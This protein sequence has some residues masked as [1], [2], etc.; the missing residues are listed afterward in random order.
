VLRVD[1]YATAAVAGSLVM[2]IGGRLGLPRTSLALLGGAVCFTL[3]ML[4]VWQN[5][6]LPKASAF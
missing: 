2:V 6:Q 1:V 4:A 5:W 3:R